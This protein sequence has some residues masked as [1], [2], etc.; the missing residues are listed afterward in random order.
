MI[1]SLAM[2]SITLEDR[3]NVQRGPERLEKQAQPL[4]QTKP[5]SRTGWGWLAG[6]SSAE[7]AL[8]AAAWQSPWRNVASCLGLHKQGR[9]QHVW[10][11]ILPWLRSALHDTNTVIMVCV[12]QRPLK[13]SGLEHWTFKETTARSG[14][15]QPLRE[16]R[17]RGSMIAILRYLMW[18]YREDNLSFHTY[19]ADEQQN[20]DCRTKVFST[21]NKSGSWPP[22]EHEHM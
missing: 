9:S 20:G 15:V 11:G 21:G 17:V 8:R 18:K 22:G 1:P 16:R 6:S 4:G 12:L 3:R 10:K 7:L 2:W 5:W 19:Q 13:Q 14:C